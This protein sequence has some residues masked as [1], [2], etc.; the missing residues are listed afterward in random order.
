MQNYPQNN[1]HS[2]PSKFTAPNQIHFSNKIL[3]ASAQLRSKAQ[4]IECLP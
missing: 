1:K 3:I 4:P 2:M